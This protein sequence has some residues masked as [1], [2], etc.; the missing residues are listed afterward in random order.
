MYVSGLRLTG[1]QGSTPL[2]VIGLVAVVSSIFDCL[3]KS[4]TQK[5]EEKT[6]MKKIS[7]LFRV[8]SGS[9]LECVTAIG[10][11]AV[12]DALLP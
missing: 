10:T 12:G 4:C 6:P 3:L 1:L 8:S 2:I 7:M 5:K 9:L 11:I